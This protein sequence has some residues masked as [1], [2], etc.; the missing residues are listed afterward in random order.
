MVTVFDPE[1]A[2]RDWQETSA[3]LAEDRLNMPTKQR[4]GVIR[5]IADTHY[6]LCP[7]CGQKMGAIIGERVIVK[8]ASRELRMSIRNQPEQDCIRC[9][10]TSHLSDMQMIQ[11]SDMQ[12]IQVR[13]RKEPVS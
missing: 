9:G 7:A 6:W 10:V 8:V 1:K 12:M 4:L 11:V 5:Q 2:L 13:S 3:I